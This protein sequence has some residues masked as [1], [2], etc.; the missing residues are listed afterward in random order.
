VPDRKVKLEEKQM[1]KL[2]KLRL[3]LGLQI[4]EASRV[5]GIHPPKLSALELARAPVG[6]TLRSRISGALGVSSSELFDEAGWPIVLEGVP[7]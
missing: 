1:T 3:D 5:Y 2:R 4:H 7:A 6:A